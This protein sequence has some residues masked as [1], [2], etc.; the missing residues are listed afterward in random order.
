M[1]ESNLSDTLKL[2]FARILYFL[3]GWATLIGIYSGGTFFWVSDQIVFDL[4]TLIICALI[5]RSCAKYALNKTKD[6]ELDYKV[7]G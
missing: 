7:M 1:S 2:L 6:K 3:G 4:I 5:T